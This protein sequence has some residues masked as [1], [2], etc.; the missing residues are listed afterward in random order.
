MA[1]ARP[2]HAFGRSLNV[3][4]SFPSVLFLNLQVQCAA[5]FFT[6]DK[7]LALATIWSD[8]GVHGYVVMPLSIA[9]HRGG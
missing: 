6:G 1:C 3:L 2:E 8:L 7:G 4:A 9:H 5:V